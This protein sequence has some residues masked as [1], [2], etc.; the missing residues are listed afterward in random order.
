[1]DFQKL[2]DDLETS[3]EVVEKVLKKIQHL[4]PVAIGSR[5]LRECLLVQLEGQKLP[6]PLAIDIIKTHFE[7]FKNKRFDKLRN[8]L[9]VDKERLQDI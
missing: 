9:D 6:D 1:M 8:L 4:D 7:D 5:N 3:T 2:A